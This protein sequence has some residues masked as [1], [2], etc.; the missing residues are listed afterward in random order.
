MFKNRQGLSDISMV[1]V[2]FPC[3]FLS[4]KSLNPNPNSN[5]LKDKQEQIRVAKLYEQSTFSI[6]VT[7][8]KMQYILL[9]N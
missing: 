4:T 1:N 9:V 2:I 3:N 8:I 6:F 5:G 7:T